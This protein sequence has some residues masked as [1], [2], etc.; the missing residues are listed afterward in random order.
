MRQDSLFSPGAPDACSWYWVIIP[1]QCSDFVSYRVIIPVVAAEGTRADDP[2]PTSASQRIR[3]PGCTEGARGANGWLGRRC[4]CLERRV[5]KNPSPSISSNPI[6]GWSAALWTMTRTCNSRRYARRR[7]ER[8]L[9][10]LRDQS[11][12]ARS[13]FLEAGAWWG[14]SAIAHF[15]RAF[16]DSLVAERK[17]IGEPTE[18]PQTR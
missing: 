12:W 3:E 6:S 2:L 18:P 15:A 13:A 1:L 11:C 5:V 8:R 14:Q 9:P 16:I 4:I 17:L 7:C 10:R